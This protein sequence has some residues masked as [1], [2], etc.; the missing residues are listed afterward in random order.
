M[1]ETLVKLAG[2]AIAVAVMV[3]VAGLARIARPV[4]ALDEDAARALLASEFPDAGCDVLWLAGDGRGLIARSGDEALII[5]R[6]GD[7][8]V[9][10]S[11]AWRLALLAPVRRGRVLLKLRDPAAPL[12]RLAVSGVSPWPPENAQEALAA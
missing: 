5:Y 3:A 11:M 7:S 12:A 8:W 9:A 1:D 4:A 6:L 10:R 2:S